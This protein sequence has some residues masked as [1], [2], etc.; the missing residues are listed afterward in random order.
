MGDGPDT[1]ELAQD[2][3]LASGGGR[4]GQ[5]D[6]ARGAGS[7]IRHPVKAPAWSVRQYLSSGQTG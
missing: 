6:Q 7:R 5:F 4:F 3:G 1:A 2:L